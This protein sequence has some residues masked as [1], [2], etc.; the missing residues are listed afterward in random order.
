MVSPSNTVGYCAVI[1]PKN[2]FWQ[3]YFIQET[4]EAKA[5]AISLMAVSLATATM[6]NPYGA[7]QASLTQAAI[8][9]KTGHIA[10]LSLA[11]RGISKSD[12]FVVIADVGIGGTHSRLVSLDANSVD[13]ARKE[14]ENLPEVQEI[15]ERLLTKLSVRDGQ[16]R[17]TAFH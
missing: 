4:P 14:I 7:L 11:L 16:G 6:A 13:E 9:Q 17:R 2:D 10:S 5:G 3:G 1:C 8:E 15:K 12:F